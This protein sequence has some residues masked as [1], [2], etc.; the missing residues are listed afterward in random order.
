MGLTNQQAADQLKTIGLN[1]LL[2]AASRS[3][4]LLF[5]G[6]FKSLLILVLIIGAGLAAS[7][8]NI[9]D[10]AVISGKEK[11]LIA[12]LNCWSHQS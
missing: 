4:W 1:R 12:N 5:F 9:K 10:A 7:I 8:G 6:Q 2:E 3:P 11:N